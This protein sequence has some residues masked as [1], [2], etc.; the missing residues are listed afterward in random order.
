MFQSQRQSQTIVAI[1]GAGGNQ[2]VPELDGRLERAAS[3]VL[4]TQ[5]LG[6]ISQSRLGS[7]QLGAEAGVVVVFAEELEIIGSRRGQE[8]APER[9]EAG[10]VEQNILAD[11]GERVVHG[12]TREAIFLLGA[13]SLF[14]SPV[15]F[16]DCHGALGVDRHRTQGQRQG[17]R[18][19]DRRG[20]RHEVAMAPPP[21]GQADRP[22]VAA[23]R[24]G[25]VG[26]P[27]LQV[28][29]QRQGRR[30]A[31]L[32]H[33][34]HRLQTDR[35]QG[36]RYVGPDRPR[37]RHLASLS[38][39]EQV[40]KRDSAPWRST[41][42]QHIQ[43]RAKAI[44]VRPG[45]EPI[46]L[47]PG[48]FGAHVARGSDDRPGRRRR[49]IRHRRRRTIPLMLTL[50]LALV[51]ARWGRVALH[52][53]GEAPVDHQGFAEVAKHDVAGLQVAMEDAPTVSVSHGF[54]GVDQ[55]TEQPTERQGPIRRHRGRPMKV[56][57]GSLEAFAANE[58]HGIVGATVGTGPEAVH[59]HNPRVFQAAGDLGL[60]EEASPVLRAVGMPLLNELQRDLAVQLVVE[61]E[62]HL[63]ESSSA[64]SRIGRNR[65]FPWLIA[66]SEATESRPHPQGGVVP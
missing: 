29:G 64:W 58:P 18:D 2:G 5:D 51:R 63:A 1:L 14:S 25:F 13:G 48:L 45:P 23:G 26:Q 16:D 4:V 62:E 65:D 10:D 57:N 56:G 54:A 3:L 59:R 7:G 8:V 41:G 47:S 33:R 37:R 50:P 46:D 24:D 21:A 6:D 22:G 49:R 38:L 44:D 20:G 66:T 40:W 9:L 42:Q 39:V 53:A 52:D 30:V 60:D 19:Q 32:G 55:P 27:V 61:G 28:I 15:A 34:R 36:H 11:S 12:A 43:R 17:R 35:L 31:A